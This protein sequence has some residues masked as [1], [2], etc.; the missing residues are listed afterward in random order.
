MTTPR[1]SSQQE[2]NITTTV[3]GEQRSW[4]VPVRL[5]LADFLRHELGLTGVHLGCEHGVCGA[6]TVWVDG[7]PA[8]SCLMLA[9]Q[10]DGRAVTTIEG[11]GAPTELHPMQEA[12]RECH[13]L[14]CGYCT[15]AMVL[16]AIS[17]LREVPNPSEEEVRE[18][19]SGNIC[20]CTGYNFIVDA[21][22][23]AA[24][25]KGGLG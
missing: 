10:I 14:Q 21:I 24:A 25:E 23:R 20:R 11:I 17:L 2:T 22:L 6:C 8:R 19:M 7:R 9:P 13:G 4:S 3:N 5:T 12:F 18:Y 16:T 15:P 1:E